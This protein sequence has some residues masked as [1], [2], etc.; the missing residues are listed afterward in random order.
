MKLRTRLYFWV[1]SL[2]VLFFVFTYFLEVYVVHS[3]LN[4][5]EKAMEEE[6]IRIAEQKREDLEEFLGIQIADIQAQ[7]DALLYRIDEYSYLRS[8]FAP[9]EKNQS[10]KTWSSAATL[11]LH[12]KWINYIQ[13][14]INGQITSLL[15]PSA[16]D[17]LPIKYH[18]ATDDLYWIVLK[19][20]TSPYIGIK[21]S[22]KDISG[23][24]SS[25]VDIDIGKFTSLFF[26]FDWKAIKDFQ[27]EGPLRV[28][29]FTY[30]DNTNESDQEDRLSLLR[31]AIIK[32][33]GE[34]KTYIESLPIDKLE[35]YSDQQLKDYIE[36]T[37]PTNVSLEGRQENIPF[38]VV[39]KGEKGSTDIIDNEFIRTFY[40]TRDRD[41]A[42]VLIW[43]LTTVLATDLFG[44]DPL[45]PLAPIG[46]SSILPGKD[47]GS[48]ILAEGIF[49]NKP[50][51]SDEEYNQLNNKNLANSPAT[52]GTIPSSIALIDYPKN[53]E[54][55]I[56]NILSIKENED[57]SLLTIAVKISNL[58]EQVALASNQTV[59]LV[60]SNKV[61]SVFN[62][63]GEQLTDSSFHHLPLDNMK[64][65]KGT[66]LIDGIEYYYLQLQPYENVD[67]HFYLFELKSKAF[68]QVTFIQQNVSN[69]I[70]QISWSMRSSAIVGLIIALIFL[71]FIAR[72][73]TKPIAKLAKATGAVSEGHY[74]DVDLPKI[75]DARKD[76]IAILCDS[77]NHMIQGLKD[78]EKVKGVLNKVVSKEI[79]EEILKGK[80]SLGG[81]EKQA[82]IVFADIRNFTHLTENMKPHD[83]I[84]LLNNA[85][86]KISH[87]VDECGG[88]IDKYVGDEAMALYGAPVTQED[89]A[90]RACLSALHM[91]EKIEEWN[92]EREKN[93]LP[94]IHIGIG[95]CTGEVVAGN[96]GAENRLNYTVLGSNVNL[97]ARLCSLAKEK[98]ILVTKNTIEGPG[99]KEMFDFEEIE[100]VLLK[101]F[102]ESIQVFKITGIKKQ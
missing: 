78:R 57:T 71:E 4:K 29:G 36:K 47:V 83:V 43:A 68:A 96:M 73:I 91:M 70:S 101:G 49:F 69:V 84:E 87:E 37:F 100:P 15:I 30:T 89:H 25:L 38:S 50:F 31:S 8:G 52:N 7:V 58:L 66:I 18:K 74:D 59:S 65:K 13:N 76:E 90:K 1:S 99:V 33:I 62:D 95:I 94:P 86:T 82:T 11:L 21:L 9:T 23:L 16:Q 63:I 41:D 80:V 48:A 92:I 24:T 17:L 32:K 55:F 45:S 102:S 2:F 81:E 88:V 27:P 42:V 60:S 54:L 12:Y 46:V 34:A 72:K 6:V 39:E 56:G 98:E 97:G 85:M 53:R 35:T 67:L 93:N 61:I 77:F 79:A 19:E 20:K 44:S 14:T 5:T 75:G 22:L 28:E 40:K 10:G 51:Y 3:H 64:D 26:F